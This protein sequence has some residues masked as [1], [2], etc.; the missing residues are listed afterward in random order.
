MIKTIF[1][2]YF[3]KFFN[4]YFTVNI[5]NY[6]ETITSCELFFFRYVDRRYTSAIFLRGLYCDGELPSWKS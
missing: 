4:L 3:T 6:V 1:Y 2:T 5:Y